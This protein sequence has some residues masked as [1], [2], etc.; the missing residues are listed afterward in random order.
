[1]KQD[2]RDDFLIAELKDLGGRASQIELA[3]ALQKA[4]LDQHTIQ[5]SKMYEELKRMNDILMEN[6]NS[7]KDHMAQTALLKDTVIKMDARLLPIELERIKKLAISEYRWGAIVLTAKIVGF[8]LGSGGLV[9]GI[10]EILG[11]VHG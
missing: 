2:E 7:L 11:R 9:W 10:I 8:L 4:A 3:I 6:T 1:M 5:D